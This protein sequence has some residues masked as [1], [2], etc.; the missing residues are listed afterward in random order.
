MFELWEYVRSPLI[1][2]GATALICFGIAFCYVIGVGAVVT[3]NIAVRWLGHRLNPVAYVAT[4]DL[5]GLFGAIVGCLFM[6]LAAYK[7]L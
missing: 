6:A 2:V 4:C 7:W 5:A 3:I 1:G